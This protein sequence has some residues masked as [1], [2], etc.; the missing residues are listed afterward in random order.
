MTKQNEL[1]KL[2]S[3]LK[4]FRKSIH[5]IPMTSKPSKITELEYKINK[6]EKETK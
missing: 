4:A 2:K 1:E 3:E 6:I 5:N